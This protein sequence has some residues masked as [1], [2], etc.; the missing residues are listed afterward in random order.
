MATCSDDEWSD[1]DETPV[2]LGLCDE[3]V[4]PGNT[5]ADMHLASIIGGRPVRYFVVV[6]VVDVNELIIIVVGL[7]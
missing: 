5:S 6:V 3:S 4:H 1:A 7:K 2:W